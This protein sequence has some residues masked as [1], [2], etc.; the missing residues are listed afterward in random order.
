[1][2]TSS[3]GAACTLRLIRRLLFSLFVLYSAALVL[4]E[5]AVSREAARVFF[6]DLRGPMPLAGINTVFSVFFLWA[7]AL[8]FFICT[9]AVDQADRRV[10]MRH[11]LFYWSQVLFFLY[12]GADDRFIVHERLGRWLGLTE[13]GI[14]DASLLVAAGLAEVGILLL[15][16]DVWNRPGRARVLLGLALLAS[17]LMTAIDLL[18]PTGA[19]L[20]LSAEDLLKLWGSIFFFLFSLETLHCHL[21][22]LKGAA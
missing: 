4:T 12:L 8:V 6:Q 19:R 2:P 11:Q 5:L 1:M 21:Q 20:Q 9:L 18:V 16:R 10:R 13:R 7:C 15:F 22:E 3:S 17:A 14:P